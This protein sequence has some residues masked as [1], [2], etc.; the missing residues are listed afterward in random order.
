MRGDWRTSGSRSF[1]KKLFIG[2]T[3]GIGPD[4]MNTIESF[5]ILPVLM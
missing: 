5:G 2:L 4:I 3:N 1:E